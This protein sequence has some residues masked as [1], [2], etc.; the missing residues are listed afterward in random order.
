VAELVRVAALT[1]YLPTMKSLGADPLPL[2]REV[3]LSPA[4]LSKPEQLM[5]AHSMI[6]LLERSAEVTNCP[7]FGLRMSPS[8]GLADLG[9]TS[10][11]IQHEPT[12]RAALSA[13]SRYRNRINP[14]LLVSIEDTDDGALIRQSFSVADAGATRQATELAL[15]A[16]FRLC[17][18]VV[19]EDW[20]PQAVCFTGE[21]PPAAELPTF[22][23]LFR[24]QPTFNAEFNGIFVASHDLGRPSQRADSAL[25]DHARKLL[26]ATKD[27]DL[28]GRSQQVERTILLQ[29][30]SGR[31]TIQSCAALLGL[32]VRTLQRDLDLEGTSFTDLLHRVRMQLA[33]Q[34]FEN[35]R[36]RVTDIAGMLGYNSMGAFIRWHQ[37]T[38]GLLPRDRRKPS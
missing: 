15:S 11:L 32:S 38:Y 19:G 13:L 24:C 35:P 30:P 17:V 2:L 33:D 7:T 22:Q 14:I 9:S 8:R 34:Y 10:L 29:L 36:T 16:L 4:L 20:Q 27:G 3:G 28:E 26:E 23:R 18:M 12:L 6:R 5:S 1:G 25:A 31:A 21:K 37:Q